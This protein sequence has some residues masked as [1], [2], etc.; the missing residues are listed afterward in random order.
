MSW[1]SKLHRKGTVKL[2]HITDEEN[3]DVVEYCLKLVNAKFIGET[4]NK[5]SYRFDIGTTVLLG[6]AS[7]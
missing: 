7:F 3:K 1:F 4:S 2:E 5:V 6:L